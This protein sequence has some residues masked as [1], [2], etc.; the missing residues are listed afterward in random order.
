LWRS[1]SYRLEPANLGVYRARVA[2]LLFANRILTAIL[3]PP[4]PFGFTLCGA[5]HSKRQNFCAYFTA[6]K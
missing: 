4:T 1:K 5:A 6:K 3:G 2:R